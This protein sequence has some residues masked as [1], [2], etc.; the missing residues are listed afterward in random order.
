MTVVAQTEK[1]IFLKRLFAAAVD[2]A[3]PRFCIPLHLPSPPRGRTVVVGAGKAAAA[4]AKAVEDHWFGDLS[5]MVVT[6]YDHGMACRRIQ[7]LEAGHPIP[8]EAGQRAAS[9]IMESVRGLGPDDLVLCLISGGG[10][11]L[12]SLPAQ[13]I[14]LAHKQTITAQL[15]QAGAAI[16][17]INCVRKHLSAIKGGRL[18]RACGPARL[19]GLIISDVAGD[20]LST[21]ASGPTT[22]DSCTFAEAR[23][24]MAKY[25]ITAPAE[26]TRLLD[27]G[28]DETPKPGD[29]VFARTEN[30][31]IATAFASLENAA[32]LA[33]DH[34][35]DPIILGDIIQGEARDVGQRQ[36]DMVRL[37][38]QKRR[39]G[40]RPQVL[41][42]GGETTVTVKGK[43]RGGS[44]AEFLLAL[45]IALDDVPVHALACDTDGIDGSENN[46]GAIITPDTLMR[47]KNRDLNAHNFLDENDSYY[48][49]AALGDLVFTGPTR[50]NVND[51][52][53]IIVED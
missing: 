6:R 15:M 13:G 51:F 33:R 44:N 7:V 48:F 39:P 14:T 29:G 38:R 5:G 10:S 40:D 26:V 30:R 46:A 49:F 41:L 9:A 45:A 17:E 3:L 22:P 23:M 34:G 43:G 8:D 19:V 16:D 28:L 1:R 2:T 4:M 31:L 37:I 21:I 32:R 47:A 52:R 42:S 24:V 12:L 18:A 50:T 35:Y 11:A 36:A 27:Q 25:A 53:A 20:T